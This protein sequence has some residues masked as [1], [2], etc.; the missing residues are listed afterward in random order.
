MGLEPTTFALRTRRSPKLSYVPAEM[1]KYHFIALRQES[2]VI[3]GPPIRFL[4]TG[5]LHGF[6]LA[7]VA[8]PAVGSVVSQSDSR[9][10]RG[11]ALDLLLNVTGVS[12]KRGEEH[13][14]V[15]AAGVRFDE[16]LHQHQTV[17]E[18]GLGNNE[19]LNNRRSAPY[20]HAEWSGEKVTLFAEHGQS[21]DLLVFISNAS[22]VHHAAQHISILKAAVDIPGVAI[23]EQ[24]SEATE[25]GIEPI[26]P[27]L[28]KTSE[29]AL[30]T[31]AYARNL[32]PFQRQEH[33]RDM[34]S[35]MMGKRDID[36]SPF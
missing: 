17:A 7:V 16:L 31:I 18:I 26:E 11:R 23:R 10:E 25:I 33:G 28:H 22:Y 15:V 14:V 1:P 29:A 20:R 30:P 12:P 2:Q 34:M 27:I 35:A 6:D 9:Q 3:R 21:Y 19:S 32:V 5:S 4:A 13:L 36:T 8:P 24:H